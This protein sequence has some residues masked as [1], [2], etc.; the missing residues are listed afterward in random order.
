M[1]IFKLV[2]ILAQTKRFCLY[3]YEFS[4]Q[5]NKRKQIDNTLSNPLIINL[6]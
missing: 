5:L 3:F 4:F 6:I 1:F 2:Y